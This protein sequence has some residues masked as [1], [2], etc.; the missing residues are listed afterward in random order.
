MRELARGVAAHTPSQAAQGA[1]G[2]SQR[3]QKVEILLPDGRV[4]T[5]TRK[6]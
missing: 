1:L 6:S 4:A 3:L 2:A 5:V